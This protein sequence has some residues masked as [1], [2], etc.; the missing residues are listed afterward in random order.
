LLIAIDAGAFGPGAL[1]DADPARF[2]ESPPRLRPIRSAAAQGDD[3][4]ALYDEI[5]GSR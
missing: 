3:L 4:L 2:R 5:L 1:I